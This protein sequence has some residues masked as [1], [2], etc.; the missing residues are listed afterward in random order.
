MVYGVLLLI[1][2]KNSS[3]SSRS[4][5]SSRSSSRATS[6]VRNAAAATS[7]A[8][9]P[10]PP[11]Q[12]EDGGRLSWGAAP[13]STIAEDCRHAHRDT[14][15]LKKSKEDKRKRS[16]QNNTSPHT[17]RRTRNPLYR[18]RSSSASS[19]RNNSPTRTA[20]RS[21]ASPAAP[22]TGATLAA[23]TRDQRIRR[24]LQGL[25]QESLEASIPEE[26]VPG[27]ED[28]LEEEDSQV[29]YESQDTSMCPEKSYP[30]EQTN[31]AES[32]TSMRGDTV[33]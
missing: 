8:L 15:Q 14:S 9:G 19:S 13:A 7:N 17:S 29:P 5:S 3:T 12:A 30:S 26:D 20:H 31:G 25:K 2:M 33:K 28:S 16:S 21:S 1:K 10:M 18:S 32:T 27:R 11:S 23:M 4:R 24:W 6:P 22:A